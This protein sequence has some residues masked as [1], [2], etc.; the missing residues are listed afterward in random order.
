MRT[1]FRNQ[2]GIT[3]VELLAVLALLSMVILLIS[4]THLFGQKQ[5]NSQSVH[6]QHE[7]SVRYAINVI[8]KEVRTSPQTISVTNNTIE[9]SNGVFR[10]QG[11]TLYKD[12]TVL[13]VG[14]EEFTVKKSGNEIMITIKSE[15]NQ[16]EKAASLSTN[17]YI[18]E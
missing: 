9:T 5:F 8:T 17:L 10:L 6:I 1:A 15:P 2:N 16:F 7:S 11:T 3:L 4:N 14:I 12:D 13:E 18:R